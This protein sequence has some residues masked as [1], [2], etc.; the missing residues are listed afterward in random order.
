MESA[1]L[2]QGR[3]FILRLVDGEVLHESVET[4][5]RDNGIL[6]AS[7]S[8][9]GAL[10]RGSEIVSGPMMP[11]GEKVVPVTIVLDGPC[12]VSGFGTVFPDEDGNPLAHIHGSVGRKGFSATGDLRP[13]AVAW[14]VMEVIVTELIGD[15]PA[16]HFSDP[17]IDGRLLEVRHGV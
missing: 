8:I 9:V 1:E 2:R 12:E 6:R 11:V 13:N 5:C 4:F 7:V 10:G 16:R 3:I 14:L 15:G 17:R